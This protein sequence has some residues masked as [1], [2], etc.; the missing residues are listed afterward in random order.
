MPSVNEKKRFLLNNI[1]IGG[2]YRQKIGQRSSVTFTVLW[3]I[4]ENI[5]SPYTNPVI[6]VGFNF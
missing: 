5:N 4:N 2:G 3:N 6:R 1:I